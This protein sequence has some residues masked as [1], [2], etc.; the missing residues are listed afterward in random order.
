MQLA[1]QTAR[2]R[3]SNHLAEDDGMAMSQLLNQAAN[4]FLRWSLGA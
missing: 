2:L 3:E 1:V 4:A